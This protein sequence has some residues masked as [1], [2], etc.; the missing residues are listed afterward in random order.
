MKAVKRVKH[1]APIPHVCPA[2][3]G[4]VR[5]VH[6]SEIY[7]RGYGKWPYAYWCQPCDYYVGTHPHTDIPLGTMAGPK[8]REQRMLAKRRFLQLVE[9]KNMTISQ[10]YSWL[11]NQLDIP[12]VEC[13]FGM[14]EEVRCKLA[15]RA[16]IKA[17][18]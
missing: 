12:P 4:E 11:S 13:H 1:P 9:L 17:M 16:C 14:F 5:L 15:A 18:K 8:L 7:G 6:N 3:D 2:C 10:G